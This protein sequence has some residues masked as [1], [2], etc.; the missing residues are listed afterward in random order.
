MTALS[1]GEDVRVVDIRALLEAHAA[2]S[3]LQTT[4]H[5]C[6]KHVL[7][8]EMNPPADLEEAL[9]MI[10]STSS[11][12]VQMGQLQQFVGYLYS[13]TNHQRVR[14]LL[15][16]LA[17]LSA[18]G[19]IA[20]RAV[21]EQLLSHL[22]PSNLLFWAEALR[23]VKEIVGGVDYKVWRESLSQSDLPPLLRRAAET[24]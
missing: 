1:G 14:W 22:D 15:S 19:V 23:T 11:H 9:R 12:E 8:P 2:K 5:G 10:F 7:I 24:S 16:L 20:C 18:S 17:S 13:Q 4:F 3:E 21:C 6:I